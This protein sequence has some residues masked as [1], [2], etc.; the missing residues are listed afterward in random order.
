M[1]DYDDS[2]QP[3]VDAGA[4]IF[5][6]AKKY[7]DIEHSFFDGKLKHFCDIFNMESMIIR[8]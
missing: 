8:N 6:T 1:D 5:R 4:E 3:L 2:T 7:W